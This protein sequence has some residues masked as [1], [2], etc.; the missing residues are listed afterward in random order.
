MPLYDAELEYYAQAELS[1]D[2]VRDIACQGGAKL[3]G[4]V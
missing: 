4:L 2:A 3:L 1:G